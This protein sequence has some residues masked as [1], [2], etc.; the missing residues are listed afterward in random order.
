[1]ADQRQVSYDPLDEYDRIAKPPMTGSPLA[2]RCRNAVPRGVLAG[3][4]GASVLWGGPVR[5]DPD[6]QTKAGIWTLSVG[7]NKRECR[8]VLRTEQSGAGMG[9]AMPPG[10]RKALPDLKSVQQ[11]SMSD[12][13]SVSFDDASGQPVLVLSS[14]Q[15]GVLHG[16]DSAGNA[17]VLSKLDPTHPTDDGPI[18]SL[19]P[20]TAGF[21]KAAA[22]KAGT[23]L[24]EVPPAVARVAPVTVT[25]TAGNYAVLRGDRDTGCMVT[26]DPSVHGPKGTLK[27]RLAPACRDQG[28]VIFDPLGWQLQA[29]AL[30]LT[31]RK[32]HTVSL[33]LDSN[34]IWV[35]AP[36][37]V[38]AL[39]LKRL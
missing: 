21:E 35:K 36:E 28:I 25:G 5:A 10:C 3:L 34:G 8:M 4:V 11:W 37:D 6:P 24:A 17:L 15:A 16:T 27:A 20:V 39:A 38:K 7:A 26:L 33:Q 23:P 13:H 31:A 12:D 32:G 18:V 9:L 14:P 30:V 19:N 29:N 2:A 22:A 1:M